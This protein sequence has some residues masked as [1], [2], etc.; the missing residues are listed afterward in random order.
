[1]FFMAMCTARPCET[2]PLR[3]G[4]GEAICTIPIFLHSCQSFRYVQVLKSLTDPK[5][6][7]PST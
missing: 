2:G 5:S 6:M 3:V 4:M 1:M 7:R